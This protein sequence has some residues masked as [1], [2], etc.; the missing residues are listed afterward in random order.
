MDFVIFASLPL[1]LMTVK[2]KLLIATQ[3]TL[4]L[5][6]L[7]CKAQMDMGVPERHSTVAATIRERIPHILKYNIA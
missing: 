6:T 5:A 1:C 4:P 2:L 7:E 3:Q